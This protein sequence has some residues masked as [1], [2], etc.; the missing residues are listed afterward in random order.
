LHESARDT[1]N[2][3]ARPGWIG[4]ALVV[5]L[6]YLVVGVGS[7]ALAASAPSERMR[8]VWR[9]GAFIVSGVVFV[10]HIA[11]EIVRRWNGA[12]AI[13]WRAAVAAALGGFGLAI[14][15]NVHDLAA[16]TG[17]RPKM[18]LALVAWPLLTGVPAFLAAL[19]LA[20]LLGMGRKRS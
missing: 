1:S 15:A 20:A 19:V 2:A 16:A 12:R 17:Y 6:I 9:W 13:A 7:A 18:L 3:T 10:A 11:L 4:L 5:A 14:S 8:F